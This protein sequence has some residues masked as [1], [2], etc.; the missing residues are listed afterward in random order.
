MA[1]NYGGFNSV[2]LGPPAKP[3]GVAQT[4]WKPT[5]QDLAS[6]LL[7]TSWK[8]DSD[9]KGAT[10]QLRQ[11]VQFQ[12]NFGEMT[13]DDVAWS[14]NDANPGVTPTSVTDGSGTW[15]GFL[16]PNKLTVVDKYTVHIAWQAFD[17]RWQ[18]WFF[19]Q[20]GLGAA[21]LSHQA[22]EQKGKDWNLN[23]IV[24]TGPFQLTAWSRGDHYTFQKFDGYWGP[25]KAQV[26][27]ITQKSVPEAAVRIAELK[28]GAADIA[29]L[30]L[31]YIPDMLKG[32]FKD[33]G[34]GAGRMQSIWFAGNLWEATSTVTGQPLQRLT[35]NNPIPWIGDPFNPTFG[36][37]PNGMTSMERAR[38]VRTALS[39]AIDR[40]QI[41]KVVNGG[42]GFATYLPYWNP[43]NPHWQSKWEYPYD[44]AKAKQLLAEAGY[45]N[46]FSIPLF[47][48]PQG[49]AFAGMGDAVAGFWQKIGLDVSVLHYQYPV[50]RPSLV[51]RTDTTPWTDVGPLEA[52]TGTPW[53]WPRGIQCS[54]L[55]R[56][57]KS[58]G[59]EA[60]QC[61][62]YYKEMSAE[63]DLQK[64][65]DMSNQFADWMYHWALGISVDAVPGLEVYN[66]NSIASWK[67]DR[68]VR[69]PYNTPQNIV[70]VS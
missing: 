48:W 50:F 51:G 59:A 2:N 37:P 36:N 17:P 45:P 44:P 49:N 30:D 55:T 67:M 32:G 22:F 21:V 40:Q 58:E 10:V 23:H 64:R 54:S 20:D 12:D 63:P 39:L 60:P 27:Q 11:G 47:A 29:D 4:L 5:E 31:R 8:L 28:S 3:M 35:Y 34:S 61:S 9:L 33:V 26:Q 43:Q 24:G 14:F 68:G 52:Y 6:P 46:G 25:D 7:A 38:L 19:G 53:D 1:S 41:V 66:P 69:Q 13:A 18:V 56:G 42:L 70:P 16:G 65:I 15:A 62:Q 57:G